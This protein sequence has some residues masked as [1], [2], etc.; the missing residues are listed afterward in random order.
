MRINFSSIR[1]GVGDFSVDVDSAIAESV[2]ATALCAVLLGRLLKQSVSQGCDASD[3]YVYSLD[4]DV[5]KGLMMSHGN[6]WDFSWLLEVSQFFW[7]LNEK[8][9]HVD[10]AQVFACIESRGWSRIDFELLG[11]AVETGYHREFDGDHE[12][13]ARE[14]MSDSCESLPDHLESHFDYDSYG[15]SLLEKYEQCEWGGRTFL[16]IR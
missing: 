13:F 4:G 14:Y 9:S 3:F 16:Y 1:T 12:E 2:D 5:E 8:P 15:E 10:E 11:E 6:S 7:Y